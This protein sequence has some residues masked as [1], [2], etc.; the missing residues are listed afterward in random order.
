M[1]KKKKFR[2]QKRKSR[3]S[4]KK[5]KKVSKKKKVRKTKKATKAKK[6]SK[7]KKVKKSKPKSSRKKKSVKPAVTPL[8]LPW[9][10]PLPGEVFIGVVEDYF[11]HVNVL[12]TTLKAPVSVGA[13]IHVRGHTTDMIQ[14]VSSM[15]IEHRTV[16]NASPGDSI[17][18]KVGQRVRKGDYIYRVAG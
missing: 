8:V 9:R 7:K 16:L 14:P 1:A 6:T 10:A 18:I 11:S 13:R 4:V 3:K 17:G 12:A 2:T 15:Q 5:R